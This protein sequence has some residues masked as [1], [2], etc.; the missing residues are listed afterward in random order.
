MRISTLFLVSGILAVALTAIAATASYI[1]YQKLMH[2]DAIDRVMYE[3]NTSVN[4]LTA[5]TGDYLLHTSERA[6]IQW[7]S[8]HDSLRIILDTPEVESLKEVKGIEKLHRHHAVI[9][10]LFSGIVAARSTLTI[11]DQLTL[12]E[13]AYAAQL[14]T[15]EQIMA[16]EATRLST[17]F[18]IVKDKAVTQFIGYSIALIAVLLAAILSLWL[19]MFTRVVKPVQTLRNGILKFGGGDLT[20]RFASTGHDEI[21]EVANSFDQTAQ[22]MCE[23]ISTRDKLN[24]TISHKAEQLEEALESEKKYS[25]LQRQFVS[26]VSHEFRTPL[27][28]IDGAAQRIIRTKD[29]ITPEKLVERSGKIRFAVERMVGLI[30]TTL[31]AENLDKGNFPFVPEV[32]D[33]KATIAIAC[34]HQ[35]EISTDHEIR[36]DIDELPPVITADWKL[37]SHTFQNFLSNAVKYS[38]INSL[39][40]VKGW[41]EGDFA[42]VS[43]KDHGVGVPESELSSLFQRFF[44][45]KTAQGIQGTG[46]GL[47]VCK[48][49]VEMHGGS[50]KVE[51]TEGKG[52]TFTVRLPIDCQNASN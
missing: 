36:M 7:I 42:M 20:F 2:A 17:H 8:K 22:I 5:L 40:E 44:R 50:V 21:S 25:D 39:I 34:D 11:N 15:T 27:S 26:L 41:T 6:K 32:R 45:A 51:S 48:Q 9:Y 43:I 3:L 31:Y 49:F 28:I 46:L 10:T 18:R 37:L 29:E 13:K 4:Q 47:S 19:M 14:Q 12:Q 16:S 52:S 23:L 35:A 24:K 33:L 30:D 38:P 1:S